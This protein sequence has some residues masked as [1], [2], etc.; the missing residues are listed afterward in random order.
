MAAC[1]RDGSV[2]A[3]ELLEAHLNQIKRWNPK[4][5]AFVSVDES[6]ARA[7]AK[8]ADEAVKARRPVGP[9]HGVPLTIKSSIDV[10]GLPCEAGTLLRRGHIPSMDA[11]LVSRLK[12]AGA[13]ILGNTTVPEF[14]MA[15]ETDNALYGRTNSAWDL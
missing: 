11:P 7:A 14:L 15:W 10:A 5:N 2:T 4:I 12:T 3:S 6:G 1:I 13:I 8:T 9:L